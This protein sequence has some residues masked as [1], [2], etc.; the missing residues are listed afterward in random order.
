MNRMQLFG[1]PGWGSGIVEAQLDWYGLEYDFERVGNLFKEAQGRQRLGAVNPLAQV[2]TLVLGDGAV[3]TESAAITLHLAELMGTDSL[4]PASGDAAR[5]TFLRWLVYF[6]ANVYPT[7]TYGDEPARFV[8]GAEAQQSF[9]SHV[10]AYAKRL[11]SVLEGVA[12]APWFLGE[13]FSALDIYV[14]VMTRWRPKRPWFAT[15]TPNLTAIALRTE[16]LPQLAA[17]WARNRLS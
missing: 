6:V 9:R 3:L 2:P 1:E 8:D 15:N 5:A 14:C 13:R 12:G 16:Q 10:D 11:Y 17:C 4:V 7:Y